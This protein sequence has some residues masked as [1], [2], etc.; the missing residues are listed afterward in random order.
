MNCCGL[1]FNSFRFNSTRNRIRS[2]RFDR[3]LFIR[4]VGLAIAFATDQQWPVFFCSDRSFLQYH[5]GFGA[6]IFW[7]CHAWYI[8]VRNNLAYHL[9]YQCCGSFVYACWSFCSSENES[10]KSH[11]VFNSS[12]KSFLPLNFTFLCFCF[13]F[14]SKCCFLLISTTLILK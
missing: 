6:K 14:F 3:N 9:H 11:S 13:F 1:F 12:G 7:V 4:S 5:S 8:C 10:C 2:K